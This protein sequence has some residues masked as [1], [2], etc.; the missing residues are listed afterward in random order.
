VT[1][2]NA[3]ILAKQF[4]NSNRLGRPQLKPMTEDAVDEYGRRYRRPVYDVT[5]RQSIRPG[6]FGGDEVSDQEAA[7][8]RLVYEREPLKVAEAERATAN[9]L[10]M[11]RPWN[12][13]ARLRVNWDNDNPQFAEYTIRTAHPPQAELTDD[14]R[15]HIETIRELSRTTYCSTREDVRAEI[16][17]RANRQTAQ[18]PLPEAQAIPQESAT[19]IPLEQAAA[20]LFTQQAKAAKPV[21]TKAESVAAPPVVGGPPVRTRRRS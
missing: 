11:L 7:T 20:D 8:P 15:Q 1:G 18:A 12:A 14:A 19:N 5:W 3:D 13:K 10:A 16:A 21:E 17:A 6:R 2:P 4:D 9:E